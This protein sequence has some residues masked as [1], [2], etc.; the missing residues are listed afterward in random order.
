MSFLRRYRYTGNRDTVIILMISDRLCFETNTGAITQT[1]MKWGLSI[2]I[3][4]PNTD[5]EKQSL[6]IKF[7]RNVSG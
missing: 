2:A 4:Q 7:K 3:M 5:A 6:T 1:I